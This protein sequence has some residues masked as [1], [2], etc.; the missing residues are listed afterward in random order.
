[1]TKTKPL[2]LAIPPRTL[3]PVI[4]LSSAAFIE[5]LESV[6]G[7]FAAKRDDAE[8][9]LGWSPKSKEPRSREPDR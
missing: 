5:V 3:T 8:D 4:P 9:D 2:L 7:D 1:M 6:R